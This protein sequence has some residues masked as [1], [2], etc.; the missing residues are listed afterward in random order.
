[1][2]LGPK[3]TTLNLLDINLQIH[4]RKLEDLPAHGSSD[5]FD[6]S[7]GQP[8]SLRSCHINSDFAAVL[9]YYIDTAPYYLAKP[10]LNVSW[11]IEPSRSA[12]AGQHCLVCA[13]F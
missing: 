13:P 3:R 2:W 12:G 8:P 6:L 4:A 5:D 9:R 1:M 7:A 11:D 10:Y